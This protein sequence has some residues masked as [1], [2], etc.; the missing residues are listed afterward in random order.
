MT[1]NTF[2]RP[3]RPKTPLDIKQLKLVTDNGEGK[4]AT[5]SV[6]LFANMPRMTVYTN[7]A[8]DADRDYGKMSAN[9]SPISWRA[10]MLLLER[11]IAFKI[12]PE[13]PEWKNKVDCFGTGWTRDRKPMPNPILLSHVWVGKDKNGI[14]WI[15]VQAPEEKNRP[16]L[17]FSILPDEWHAFQHKTGEG[18][19][20]SEASCLW[21]EAY[22]NCMEDLIAHMQVTSYTEPPPPKDGGYQGNNGGN[23][24][25]QGGNGG[26]YQNNN[27]GGGGSRPAPQTSDDEDIPF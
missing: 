21:A 26:G 14:V 15:A 19:S 2:Q 8:A 13:E 4:K 12:T 25:G 6:G 5:L 17:K 10:I 20:K 18:F 1:G 22:K 7:I 11:A 9:L 27:N 3:P 16:R 24:G 23:R